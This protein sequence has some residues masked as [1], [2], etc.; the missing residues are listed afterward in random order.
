MPVKSGLTDYQMTKLYHAGVTDAQI[1][2][3]YGISV[4]AVGAR[5]RRL[6]LPRKRIAQQVNEALIS[7]WGVIPD[8]SHHI[9]HTAKALKTYLRMRLGDSSV[10]ASQRR[11]TD[12]WVERLKKRDVVVCYDPERVGGWY[13]R[14]R[15]ASD[16]RRVADWPAS[17]P[18]PSVEFKR[19]LDLPED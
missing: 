4:S 3:M 10:S 18:F 8:K 13:Y 2:E 1:A 12:S 19:A 15:V 14:P 9:E 5:R 7:R 11:T 16:E 17:I 6:N